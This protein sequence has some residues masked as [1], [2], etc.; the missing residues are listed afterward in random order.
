MD[1]CNTGDFTNSSWLASAIDTNLDPETEENQ[2]SSQKDDDN[3]D[4]DNNGDD[5]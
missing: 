2:E 1:S 4:N 3:D 5:E